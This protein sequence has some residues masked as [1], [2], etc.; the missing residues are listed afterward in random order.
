MAQAKM[1]HRTVSLK[2]VQRLVLKAFS[3]KH[4]GKSSPKVPMIW[5]PPGIGKSDI[6]RTIADSG[7]LG[8]CAVIDIRLALMEPTDIRG[9]PYL[10]KNASGNETMLWAPSEE[11][12]S[13]EFCKDYDHVILFLDELPN[14][15]PSVQAAS[16][17]LMLNRRVGPYHLPDNVR[18]IVAGNRKTDG[19][20]TFNMP[21]PLKNRMSHFEVEADADVWIEWA[22]MHEVHA[23]VIGYISFAKGDIFKMAD[24]RID[25]RAFPTPRSW[26]FVSDYLNDPDE[27]TEEDLYELVAGTIGEGVTANFMAKRALGKDVPNPSDILSGKVTEMKNRE[28]SACFALTVN[29]CRELQIA[30]EKIGESDPK[31]FHKQ[32]DRFFKFMMTQFTADMCVMGSR[33][34]LFEFDLALDPTELETFDEF[35][36]RFGESVSKA[37]SG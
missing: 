17:Q 6:V 27:I 33:T 34:A 22:I 23:D 36:E 13:E 8:N 31:E 29:L 26:T 7:K 35:H 12:P 28:I 20:G 11:F 4:L 15:A 37:I 3:A 21:I 5:G 24:G 32:A 1:E 9:I 2:Q 18:V 14:A 25:E 10:G 16:Y 19:G 30:S